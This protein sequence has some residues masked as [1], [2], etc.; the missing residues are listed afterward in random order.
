M[1]S[2]S[3]SGSI[4]RAHNE[5]V[6]HDW[7]GQ[8]GVQSLL[9]AAVAGL[10]HGLHV[11]ADALAWQRTAA[12]DKLRTNAAVQLTLVAVGALQYAGVFR[13]VMASAFAAALSLAPAA[14]PWRMLCYLAA[15]VGRA[16]AAA[17]VAALYAA[18]QKRWP[19][20]AGPPNR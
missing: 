1:A 20:R 16:S 12:A 9:G 5:A 14:V 3:A 7:S 10:R 19:R 4:K 2:G 6:L 18:G 15:D 13:A 17:A 8:Y 11:P